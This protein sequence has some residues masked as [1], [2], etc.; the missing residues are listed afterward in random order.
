MDREDKRALRRIGRNAFYALLA[1]VALGIVKCLFKMRR[2]LLTSLL[3]EI[4]SLDPLKWA[5]VV[6]GLSS[7]RLLQKK[8]QNVCSASQA[9]AG[10]L[11]A[12]PVVV[13][14]KSTRTE[15]ALYAFMRALHCGVVTY[16]FPVLPQPLQN[17]GHYDTV[18]MML[19]S[20]EILYSYMFFPK[21]HVQSYQAFLLR[22]TIADRNVLSAT[23]GVHRNL[24]VPELVLVSLKNNL[25]VPAVESHTSHLC[26]LYHP[27]EGCNRYT[28]SFLWK[29]L[30][31]I[32]IPLY[33]P[34]KFVTTVVFKP[35]SIVKRPVATVLKIVGSAL[36]SSAFLS[37][38]CLAA[39]RTICFYATRDIR[40]PFLL[41]TLGGIT[42]G[43]AT[44]LEDKPRRLDLAIYCTMQALRSATFL[45]NRRGLVQL[46]SKG[47]LTALYVASMS[48]L[49]YIF[50]RHPQSLHPTIKKTFGAILSE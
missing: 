6:G 35:S 7:Y 36:K 14:N 45:L 19:A 11:A 3:Q 29:H 32:S 44:L 5:A 15:L 18:M 22:A 40:S 26:K 41:C 16:L 17:F 33:F 10:A 20:T 13:M 1:R 42:S 50:D 30:T 12:L 28:L 9:I 31:T 37:L 46:P 25:P 8:L 39:M 2:P 49:F 4:I 43:A 27:N 24:V 23:A 48:F 38:Y 47:Q 21:S 34:L